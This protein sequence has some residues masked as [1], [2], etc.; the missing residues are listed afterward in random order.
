MML[1]IKKNDIR[2]DDMMKKWKV[3]LKST[4]IWS[5]IAE[6]EDSESKL[7]SWISIFGF[8]AL[9]AC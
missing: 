2:S 7:I 6:D 3:Y 5:S 4:K 8:D 9:K 1:K